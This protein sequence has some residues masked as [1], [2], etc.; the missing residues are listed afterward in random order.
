MTR[1]DTALSTSEIQ[2][3]LSKALQSDL[4]HGVRWLNEKASKEFA[5]KYP[6]LLEALNE[7]QELE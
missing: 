1:L 6:A 7:I 2:D 5:T 3:K 4:E